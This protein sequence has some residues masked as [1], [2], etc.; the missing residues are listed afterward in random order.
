MAYRYASNP[1]EAEDIAQ[2][3]L[4]RAWRRRSTLREAD[5]RNQWLATIVRN[6]AFRQHARVR[7]DPIATIETH[8]GA[9]DAQVVATVERA[10]LHAALKRLSERDRAAARAALRRGPDPAGDRPPARHPRRDRQGAAAP[11]PQQAAPR[12]RR[13]SDWPPRRPGASPPAAACGPDVGDQHREQ[14]VGQAVA[15]AGR[16]GRPAARRRSG[17]RP[18]PADISEMFS[19]SSRPPASSR[20]GLEVLGEAGDRVPVQLAGVGAGGGDLDHGGPGQ[21]RVERRRGRRSSS[22]PSRHPL[23]PGLPRRRS[24]RRPRRRP[25]R[26]AS[27]RRRGSSRACPRS[28]CR[29]WCGRFRPPRSRRRRRSP[30]SPWRRRRGS[31][32][33]GSV[34]A[35]IRS[36]PS[37]RFRGR[38]NYRVHSS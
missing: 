9:E 4:L 20:P 8:E 5:R 36:L 35:A 22:G 1:S 24:W 38:L 2:D 13:F 29:R 16:R 32:P 11:R 12:L 37:A 7:P 30:C 25:A 34:D 27:R 18:R 33:P 14:Q 17:R 23:H 26:P 15:A 6:E 28:A 10:D 3:A 31:S 19:G 21:L